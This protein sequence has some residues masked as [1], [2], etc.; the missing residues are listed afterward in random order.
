MSAKEIAPQLNITDVSVYYPLRKLNGTIK[1]R[2]KKE[3]A[4]VAAPVTSLRESAV[5]RLPDDIPGVHHHGPM[6]YDDHYK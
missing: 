4:P 6:L 2:A 5:G 3:D 1:P